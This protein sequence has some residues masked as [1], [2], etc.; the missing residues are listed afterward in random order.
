M[1]HLKVHTVSVRKRAE[2]NVDFGFRGFC[3][4][5]GLV[6]GTTVS[7]LHQSAE[8]ADYCEIFNQFGVKKSKRAAA[9]ADGLW[10][11]VL[12]EVLSFLKT[13]LIAGPQHVLEMARGASFLRSLPAAAFRTVVALLPPLPPGIHWC[14]RV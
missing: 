3:S 6:D 5:S 1:G 7:Q 4:F 2:A 10:Q 12:Q 8:A 9:K 13:C 11:D 14:R